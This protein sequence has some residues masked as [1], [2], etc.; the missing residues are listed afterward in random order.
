MSLPGLCSFELKCVG[1]DRFQMG[2]VV[3]KAQKNAAPM[4]MFRLFPF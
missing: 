1:L 4:F 2:S 3:S